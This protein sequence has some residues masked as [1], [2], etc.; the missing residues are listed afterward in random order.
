MAAARSSVQKGGETW[1]S[2]WVMAWCEL[3]SIVGGEGV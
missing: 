1:R 3:S 2:D